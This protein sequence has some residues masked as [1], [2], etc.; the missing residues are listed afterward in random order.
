[1]ARERSAG[2]NV[3]GGLLG[4][5]LILFSAIGFASAGT[6]SRLAADNGLSTISFITWR[7]TVGGIAVAIA[8]GLV[9][10]LGRMRMPRLNELSRSDRTSLALVAI[11]S[12]LVNLAMFIAFSRTTIALAMICFYTYPGLV[13][14]G[15]VRF[16]GEPLDRMRA[17]AL[18]VASLGLVVVLAPSLLQNGLVVD[19]LGIVLALVASVFQA[20]CVL[21]AGRGFG[22]VAPLL[23]S[24]VL[25]LV[26]AVVYI[27]IAALTGQF[28]TLAEPFQDASL[29][30][31]ILLGGIVGAALPSVANLTGILIIGAARTA[32]LMM[33][34]AVVGVI[35]AVLFLG[36]HPSPFQVVGGAAVLAAGA[37]LQLPRRGERLLVE[38]AHPT[39]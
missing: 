25:I 15:A 4:P 17:G 30:P 5:A 22:A 38:S 16:F 34:E 7:S 32:I 26:S 31:F 14:L 19:P 27:G 12:T 33:L 23:S 2:S 35:L 21:L 13:T 39:V 11:G 36:E 10:A 6:T 3:T 20:G 9:L 18:A 29:W 28:G 8:F 37:V 24:A 1:V